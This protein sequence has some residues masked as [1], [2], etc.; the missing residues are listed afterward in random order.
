MGLEKQTNPPP[1]KKK[2]IDIFYPLFRHISM[3]L[4]VTDLKL[5]HIFDMFI[6]SL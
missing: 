1:P 2:G 5:L 4:M 6:E 3:S